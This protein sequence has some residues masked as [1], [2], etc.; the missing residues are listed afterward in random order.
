ML[1]S[2]IATVISSVALV[3]VVVGLLIQA[4]QLQA[5]QLQAV[6]SLH[7]D[8]IKLAIENPSIAV[9]MEGDID[10]EEVPKAAYLNLYFTFLRTSY[11]LRAISKEAVDFQAG[12]FFASEYP[13]S[14]WARARDAYKIEAATARE[15]EFAALIDTKFQETM[16]QN[17]STDEQAGDSSTKAT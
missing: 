17:Q 16:S 5:S 12:R 3:G 2:L 10:P 13:R 7:V 9:A 4:R 8:F 6:R 1:L 11:S 14:W 15:K